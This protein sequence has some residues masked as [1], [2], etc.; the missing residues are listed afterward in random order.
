L[1]SRVCDGGSPCPIILFWREPA[2]VLCTSQTFQMLPT[3]LRCV[4]GMRTALPQGRGSHSGDRARL[5]LAL[6]RS[7][8]RLLNLLSARLSRSTGSR[9]GT[10]PE[11]LGRHL[12]Y[13]VR[14]CFA[15]TAWASK[16]LVS[17]NCYVSTLEAD[18]PSVERAK[19]HPEVV[20]VY[21]DTIR[22]TDNSADHSA[23]SCVRSFGRWGRNRTGGPTARVLK[24]FHWEALFLVPMEYSSGL[25]I[26]VAFFPPGR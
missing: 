9:R 23:G 3:C 22:T 20:E 5:A 18:T 10:Q 11:D 15:V 16:S 8:R 13:E 12:R 7:F 14:L 2:H 24:T 17:R 4:I 19:H 6:V 25:S 1:D 21:L 26:R